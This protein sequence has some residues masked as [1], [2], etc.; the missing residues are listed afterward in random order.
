[1]LAFTAVSAVL[2]ASQDTAAVKVAES[3]TMEKLECLPAGENSVAVVT[4]E[5]QPAGTWVRVFFRRLNPEGSAYFVE[6]VPSDA[7]TSWASLPKPKEEAQEE[8]TDEWWQVLKTRDWMQYR[9]RNRQ[10]L[11]DWLGEQDFEAA[12]A[13]AALVDADGQ[14]LERSEV[15]LVPVRNSTECAVTLDDKQIG[16]A[17]SLTV[18]E[19]DAIQAE[20]ELFHWKCDGVVTRI[21]SEGILNADEACR[22]CLTGSG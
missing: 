14:M 19:T 6:G 16:E 4:A 11:E 20:R 17:G 15:Q 2:A 22:G 8:L 1:M 9:G 21:S 13:F 3:L 7:D 5:N 12:E 10:W 18:G